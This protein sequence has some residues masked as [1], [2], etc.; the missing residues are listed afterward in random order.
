M[1]NRIEKLQHDF[2]WGGVGEEFK[3]HLVSWHKVCSSIFEEVGGLKF[4]YV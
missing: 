4:T 1:T 3:C 2:L